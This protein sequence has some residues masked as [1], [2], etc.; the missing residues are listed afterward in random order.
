MN[1]DLLFEEAI[2]ILFK[3]ILHSKLSFNC[4]DFTSIALLYPGG[5]I[6]N[7]IIAQEK[8]SRNAM[9][10][11]TWLTLWISWKND[12]ILHGTVILSPTEIGDISKLYQVQRIPVDFG[13]ASKVM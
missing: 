8:T 9:E 12:C 1:I 11:D 10:R 4:M 5:P 13:E 6:S 3:H 2:N 7:S